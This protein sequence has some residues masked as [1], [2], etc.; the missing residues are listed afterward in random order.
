MA[1]R[2]SS[3]VC[4]AVGAILGL[5]PGCAL[6]IEASLLKHR[7]GQE[8]KVAR[9][10][11]QLC[12]KQLSND[13]E[14]RRFY[15]RYWRSTC[16]FNSKK[17]EHDKQRLRHEQDVLAH[18]KTYLENSTRTK[19]EYEILRIST[20]K[21]DRAFTHLDASELVSKMWDSFLEIESIRQ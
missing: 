13:T 15:D 19:W 5:V 21:T 18:R 1:P 12:R 16:D 11:L 7:L 8:R 10:V 17:F 2:S 6:M 9:C 3:K 4:F 20:K 14:T